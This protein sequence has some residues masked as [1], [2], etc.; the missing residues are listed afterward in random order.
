MFYLFICLL[1]AKNSDGVGNSKSSEPI[2]FSDI[3]RKKGVTHAGF[4]PIGCCDFFHREKFLWIPAL[5]LNSSYQT[6]C[7]Q[8]QQQH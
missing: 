8:Q 4:F 6:L 3:A 5:H 1:R 2:I 7:Q